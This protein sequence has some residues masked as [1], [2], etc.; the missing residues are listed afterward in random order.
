MLF[1]TFMQKKPDL[2]EKQGVKNMAM[3]SEK[4]LYATFCK[5]IPGGRK[6]ENSYHANQ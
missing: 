3:F 6:D 2:S 1:L 4:E 5:L